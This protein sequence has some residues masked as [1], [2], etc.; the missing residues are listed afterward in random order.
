MSVVESVV[1]VWTAVSTWYVSTFQSVQPIFY[2]AESGLTFI[3]VLACIGAGL[4]IIMGLVMVIRSF[5]K[6]H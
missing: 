6:A 4:S 3:G 2:N 1:D 5:L